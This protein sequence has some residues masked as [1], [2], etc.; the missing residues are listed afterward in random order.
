MAERSGHSKVVQEG[1]E[2]VCR[3]CGCRWDAQDERDNAI[4]ECSTLGRFALGFRFNGGGY[5]DTSTFHER[6]AKR[7]ARQ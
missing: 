2:Y 6:K 4:P 3:A 1:D 7:K 5:K